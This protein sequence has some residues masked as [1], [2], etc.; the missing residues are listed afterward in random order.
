MQYFGPK[1]GFSVMVDKDIKAR[2]L[3]NN[4]RIKIETIK[5]G[6]KIARDTEY[7]VEKLKEININ[8]ENYIDNQDLL[9]DILQSL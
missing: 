1:F 9:P 8:E 2:Q 4:F 3:V 7:L 5:K 6:Y